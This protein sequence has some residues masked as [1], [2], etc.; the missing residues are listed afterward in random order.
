ME[1]Q[2]TALLARL[3]TFSIHFQWETVFLLAHLGTGEIQPQIN[4][5]N[6]IKEVFHLLPVPPAMG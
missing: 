5:F 4:A 2:V 1:M 6:A 3:Q